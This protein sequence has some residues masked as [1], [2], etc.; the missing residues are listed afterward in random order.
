MM[1]LKT[2]YDK[3]FLKCLCIL[4]IKHLMTI[5][6]KKTEI[7]LLVLLSNI[8]LNWGQRSNLI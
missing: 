4:F 6:R 8:S 3:G 5:V 1:S 2:I 7:L